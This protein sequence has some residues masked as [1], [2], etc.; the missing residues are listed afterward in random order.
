MA[1]LFQ[2]RLG[3]VVM[4]A[5]NRDGQRFIYQYCQAAEV[6]AP[7]K[8]TKRIHAAWWLMII[9]KNICNIMDNDKISPP[10]ARNRRG[11]V[12]DEVVVP[13]RALIATSW[14]TTAAGGGQLDIF[15]G[16]YIAQI[17]LLT[18]E[19][20]CK[21]KHY[22]HHIFYHNF[23]GRGWLADHLLGKPLHLRSWRAGASFHV[24]ETST[25]VW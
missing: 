25:S 13:S 1:G 24:A 8:K 6:L 21:L 23:L 15:I 16:N 4:A 14:G 9:S 17:T 7:S 12:W 10:G 20:L 11:G 22:H 5:P 3:D 18:A 19:T 2:V